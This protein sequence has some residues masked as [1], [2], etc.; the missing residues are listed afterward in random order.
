MEMT[1]KSYSANFGSPGENI[2]V[3]IIHAEDG[4]VSIKIQGAVYKEL[5]PNFLDDLRFAVRAT[6]NRMR[7][8]YGEGD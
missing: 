5:I 7:W 3:E 6:E 8:I 1:N 2:Q 4:T